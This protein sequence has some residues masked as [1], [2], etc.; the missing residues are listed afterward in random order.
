[1]ELTV[2]KI[3]IDGDVVSLRC[4]DQQSSRVY[5]IL[6][7]DYLR[8][9]LS[10]GDI[11]D[12]QTAER[13]N[14]QHTYCYCYRRCLRK[15]A[16]S[17]HTEKEMR[18][19]LSRMKELPAEDGERI[20]NTL[21]QTGYLND[22]N[23]AASQLYAD[24]NKL[25]GRRKTLYNLTGRGI[26]RQTACQ[27]IADVDEQEELRRG[28]LKAQKIWSRDPNRSYRQKLQH[29]RQQ[30]AADGF[31]DIDGILQQLDLKMDE[32]NEKANLQRDLAKAVTRYG[33]KY[34]GTQL[35]RQTVQYLLS[36]GYEYSMIQEC[37]GQEGEEYEDQ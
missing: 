25:L 31:E 36:R 4:E 10:A 15:L 7:D 33:K 9:P 24:Q 35:R 11:V 19:V 26:D 17:D 27:L 34:S 8:Q 20:L 32:E 16:A 30:L 12:Q 18:Q 5:R 3:K 6:L 37:Y 22:G 29:L 23:V 13:L 28:V 21:K 2:K 1:M 14:Q